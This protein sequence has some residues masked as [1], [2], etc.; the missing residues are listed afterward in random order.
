MEND[1]KELLRYL[2][3][4]LASALKNVDSSTVREVRL[5]RDRPLILSTSS[6]ERFVLRD[7]Q[8]SAV[9]CPTTVTVTEADLEETVL[10][11]CGYAVHTHQEELRG[12]YITTESGLRA[13]VGGTVSVTDGAPI[14]VGTITSLCL[15]VSRS[16]PGCSAELC[17]RLRQEGTFPSVLL[18]GQPSSGKTSLLRDMAKRLSEGAD[19]RR[20]RVTVVDERGELSYGDGL[21]YCDII[22]GC[23]K[24]EGIRRAIR[25]FAPDIVIFDEWGTAAE[26]EAVLDALPCGVAVVTSCHAGTL[27]ALHNRPV[28]RPAVTAGFTWLVELTGYRAPGQWNRVIKVDDWLAEM[29]GNSVAGGGVSASWQQA[30]GLTPRTGEDMGAGITPGRDAGDADRLQHPTDT[31]V[32]ERAVPHRQPD[33]VAVPAGALPLCAGEDGGVLADERREESDCLV[34]ARPRAA[35]GVWR[36]AGADGYCRADSALP[37]VCRPV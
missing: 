10:R 31:A 29:A 26:T 25:L 24:P 15:R 6:G 37:G 27:Q 12:G 3:R 17:R 14:T 18:C 8:T 16:H 11:L 9:R 28:L 34:A 21:G 23:P 30:D 35:G 1:W 20:W 7:G 2:P 5:R 13:G 4:Q 33:C 19:G 36:T 32:I 22:R